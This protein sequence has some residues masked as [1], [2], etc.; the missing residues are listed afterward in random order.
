[1]TAND[2]FSSS[3]DNFLPPS[4]DRPPSNANRDWSNG[5][6]YDGSVGRKLNVA[7]ICPSAAVASAMSRRNAFAVSSRS[8]A[9]RGRSP[10]IKRRMARSSM[11]RRREKAVVPPKSWT[12]Y[13]KCSRRSSIENDAAIV[14]PFRSLSAVIDYLADEAQSS[15]IRSQ[16]HCSDLAKADLLFRHPDLIAR[17]TR[18]RALTFASAWSPKTLNDVAMVRQRLKGF[19]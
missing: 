10:L 13:A 7:A 8:P 4:P 2:Q 5:V 18:K 3:A 16:Q 14:S 1:M 19:V 9:P 15:Q 11:P 6:N 17:S 12:Q